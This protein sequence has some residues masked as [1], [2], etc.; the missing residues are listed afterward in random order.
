MVDSMPRL[1]RM[2]LEEDF[3]GELRDTWPRRPTGHACVGGTG[4]LPKR[5]GGH[6]C[7]GIAQQ[8]VVQH[9]EVLGS[10]LQG[11]LAIDR[12]AADHCAIPIGIAWAAERAL[13]DIAKA[14]A[15]VGAGIHR[16]RVRGLIEPVDT[17]LGGRAIPYVGPAMVL[18]ATGRQRDPG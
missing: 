9:V 15:A 13:D 7:G 14:G 8:G 18:R 16:Q 11:G 1:S 4:D 3:Q 2:G 5:G 17:G 12:E 10:E 6:A